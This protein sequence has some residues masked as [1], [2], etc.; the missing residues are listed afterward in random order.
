[1]A[2]VQG[3]FAMSLLSAAPTWAQVPATVLHRF[4]GFTSATGPRGGLV[5]AA[6]GNYYG[7]RAGGGAFGAG[8]VFRMTPD[9]VVTAI[10]D[11]RGGA[12]GGHPNSPLTLGPDGTLVGL[13]AI[14]SGDSYVSASFRLSRDGSAYQLLHRFDPVTEGRDSDPGRIL[15]A[16]DGNFY[17][18]LSFD[19]TRRSGAVYR[20]TPEGTVTILHGFTGS[21]DGQR[22]L[23]LVQGPD[24]GF[25]GVTAGGGACSGRPGEY[26]GPGFGGGGTLFY[27]T[28]AGAVTILHS[29]P[30]GP[31]D[32]IGP[33]DLIL[34]ANGAI[35]GITASVSC[36]SSP[37]GAGAVFEWTPGGGYRVLT[38]TAQSPN[39]LMQTKDGTLYGTALKFDSGCYK[40]GSIFRIRPDGQPVNLHPFVNLQDGVLPHGLI[41]GSDGALYSTTERGGTSADSHGEGFGTIFRV[42]RD[43]TF[44]QLHRFMGNEEGAFADAPL[45][46]ATDGNFYGTTRYGGIHNRGTVYRMTPVGSV[47]VL[48]TFTGGVD[49]A[50]PTGIVQASDGFLYG[51]TTSKGAVNKGTIF[52]ISLAGAFSVIHAFAP[53][54]PNGGARLVLGANGLLYGTSW[55]GGNAGAGTIFQVTLN[56]TVTIIHHFN[57]RDSPTTAPLL[58]ARDGYLYGATTWNVF[59]I[60]LN[61]GFTMLNAVDG[62]TSELV[63]GSD[64][65]IY[66]LA[67][68]RGRVFRIT[69]AGAFQIVTAAVG[70]FCSDYRW[71]PA[72][73]IATDRRGNVFVYGSGTLFRDA[74]AS[75]RGPSYG[76]IAAIGIDGTV[77]PFHQDNIGG[78]TPRSLIQG[79]GGMFYMTT[80]DFGGAGGAVLRLSPSAAVAPRI[81]FTFTAPAPGSGL[82]LGWSAAGS[83]ARYTILRTGGAAG[84][85]TVASG[86]VGTTFADTTVVPGVVYSYV[87]IAMLPGGESLQSAATSIPWLSPA[88]RT[89]TVTTVGDYDGDGKADLTV[90]RQSTGSWFNHQSSSGALWSPA[91]GAPTLGDRPVPADY[92]GDG[93]TDLAVYRQTSA[94]WFI[95]RSSTDVH[96]QTP[97]GAPTLGDLPVPADYDGDGHADLAVYRATTGEWLIR[98]STDG[99]LLQWGW[100]A[101][102]L[103]DLPVPADYDGDGQTDVAVYRATTGEWLI[104][105]SAGATLRPL[106]WGSPA[107]GDVPVPA[108]YD[109]DGHADLAVY[110]ARTGEWFIHRSTDGALV[111]FGWGS[112][113]HGDVPVVG[114]YDGDGRADVAVYR[115][116]T[117]EWFILGS[118]GS[119]ISGQ[120]GAPSLGDAVRL[121]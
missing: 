9:G 97:W 51:A 43:D 52:R 118:T 18:T 67:R 47:Q 109:G 71:E 102:T 96:V 95:R 15:L 89:P 29:F 35:Y 90:Y 120:W 1:M 14:E 56:G 75:Q 24:G 86:L 49:G 28:P 92:D 21:P 93:V 33:T 30:L 65:S 84:Q 4:T 53:P 23:A 41:E 72:V 55:Q 79:S 62:G 40:C 113:A 32:G 98:R 39:S 12:E 2:I 36:G 68:C 100:G 34:G 3:I 38:W 45:V 63:Q 88:S 83:D 73:G 48:Y 74:F 20:M 116:L 58:R 115:V 61:G 37:C 64:G 59:R 105:H 60:G 112:P 85:T 22:P 26:C 50:Y 66:G 107:H 91:W 101:P 111:Q 5:L 8:S 70:S 82:T 76:R 94:D 54:G 19:E 117:A 31:A 99:T 42:G 87:V 110:R 57:E 10:Y 80:G 44:K 114:D 6:D 104:R 77:I 17:G 11:F 27:M 106:G 7:T 121:F 81:L 46:Q 25:F 78:S 13:M 119:V 69:P 16:R 103:G 108:D